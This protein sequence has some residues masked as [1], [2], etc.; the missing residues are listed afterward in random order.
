MSAST[1]EVR[2]PQPRPKETERSSRRWPIGTVV[3]NACYFVFGAFAAPLAAE[4]LRSLPGRRLRVRMPHV[5]ACFVGA[6]LLFDLVVVRPRYARGPEPFSEFLR[7]QLRETVPLLAVLFTARPRSIDV[8]DRYA[9]VFLTVGAVI[10]ALGALDYLAAVSSGGAGSPLHMVRRDPS[11]L[12]IFVAWLRAHNAAGGLYSALAAMSLWWFLL[13]RI[14]VWILL[15]NLLGLALTLSR[16][17]YL[18]FVVVAL[19]AFI[20]RGPVRRRG[21]LFVALAVAVTLAFAIAP[22]RERLGGG[23]SSTD[24]GRST[25]TEIWSAALRDFTQHPVLGIGWGNFQPA[26]GEH[27]HNSYLQV[28]AELGVVGLGLI[29]WWLGSVVWELARRR[30]HDLLAALATL[31]VTAT[32][33]HNFGSPSITAPVFVLCGMAISASRAT[34]PSPLPRTAGSV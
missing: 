4:A 2:S 13:R 25:R 7:W 18:G 16:S 32:L 15:G 21:R 1:L 22:L 30:R 3:A 27:A 9:R 31:L 6:Y 28:A 23:L 14:P 8:V 10:A 29:G 33:D 17:G 11:G 26:P 12:Y 20:V 34:M 24:Y 5:V 19:V